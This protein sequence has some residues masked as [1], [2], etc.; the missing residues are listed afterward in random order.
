M[1]RNP[2][3]YKQLFQSLRPRLSLSTFPHSQHKASAS[4]KFSSMAKLDLNI[5]NLKLPDGNEIP[6][7]SKPHMTSTLPLLDVG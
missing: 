2:L 1:L 3:A 4:L 7:V 6:M 5:P